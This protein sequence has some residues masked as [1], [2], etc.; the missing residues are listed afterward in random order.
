MTRSRGLAKRLTPLDRKKLKRISGVCKMEAP[1]LT[2]H[3]LSASYDS[4]MLF[5][6]LSFAVHPGER[7]G[8]V[9]PNGAGKST[10]FKMIKG[11]L[12]PVQGI[13]SVRN[14]VRVTFIDQKINF[15]ENLTVEQILRESLPIEYDTDSRILKFEQDLEQHF[16]LTEAN[17]NLLEN[18]KWL[19]KFTDLNVQM[20]EVTGTPTNNI[21]Q[22]A[23]KAGNLLELALTSFK[24]LSGGQQKRVQIVAAL[25]KNPNLIL[26]DEPTN[27]LD[28]QT[29]EWL[30]EFLLQIVEQGFSLFG[31]KSNEREIEPVAYVI[32]SHDRA[33]LDTLVNKI[34][35][36]EQGEA[37]QYEGNYEA[38]SQLK[39]EH[40]LVEEKTRSKMANTMRRELEWLRSGTKARTTKQTARIER[41]K[42]LD[43]N[44]NAKEKKASLNKNAELTFSAQMVGE[45]RDK[46]D[47]IVARHHNLGEQELI[48]IQGVSLAHPASQHD[49][50]FLFQNLNLIIKPRMRVAILGPNG[51]GKSTLLNYIV[52]K[53]KPHSGEIKFH[54]LTHISY[55]D[56]KR[57]NMDYNDTIRKNIAPEGDNVFFGGKYIHI[58][59]YLERFLF[60][61]YDV[62]RTVSELSGGEQA[63]LLLAKLMLEQGNV[64][65]LDEPTNDLDIPTLQVLEKNLIDF[66]GGVLFTSHD[67]YF[68]QKVAT[69]LLT[70][71][72]EINKN[73]QWGL[74]PDLN[75]ALEHVEKFQEEQ[76]AS[77]K[78]Q[79]KLVNKNNVE[80][81]T[82]SV[83]NKKRKLSFKEQKEYDVLEKRILHLEEIIPPLSA[84]LDELYAAQK[85]PSE[86]KKLVE[87]ID[88]F[89]KELN[90]CY[91]RWEKF[92]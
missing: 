91:V 84:K 27:H 64:L 4:T 73:A 59:S 34:L 14:N 51:S 20:S 1:Y 77:R 45:Q 47:F 50:H 33:L 85:S 54:D 9:G 53:L 92:V 30:E 13:I 46:D 58:M 25:L 23:L 10:I 88:T 86:T 82:S 78:N 65:I 89:Q 8:I 24:N 22:S 80:N 41:A 37:K 28:V 67:R 3:N 40:M 72:G 68:M 2:C 56:Q 52:D 16:K 38:Y 6:E 11:L 26:M 69:T 49:E 87:E 18:E 17:P 48:K 81:L 35:E 61:K 66:N 32:I 12:K 57:N 63:R 31:F 21:I 70:Y 60:Y 75:Q 42:A 71:L 44:L 39:L 5:K 74:F 62:N 43:K 55:F 36:V 15:D 76:K 79:T 83:E 90:S 29:V 19:E 7:W